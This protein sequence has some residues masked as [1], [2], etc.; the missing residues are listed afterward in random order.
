[1]LM[2]AGCPAALLLGVDLVNGPLG[3]VLVGVGVAVGT[4]TVWVGVGEATLVGVMLAAEVTV[5]GLSVSAKLHQFPLS[6][7]VAPVDLTATTSQKY[8][9]PGSSPLMTALEL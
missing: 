9:I 6:R 8:V 1:M 4:L 3:I 7:K 2:F 5:G